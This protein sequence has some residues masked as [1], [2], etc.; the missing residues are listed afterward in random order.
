MSAD[1]ETHLDILG[2]QPLLGIYTQISLCYTVKDES[3]HPQIVEI[4]KAGLERLATSFPWLAGQVVR[5][6]S[7]SKIKPFE[8][9]PTLI[10][11][12]WRDDST[13]SSMDVL[14]Q[15]RFPF[16]LLDESIIAS[17]NTLPT[18]VEMSSP[19][20]VLALQ[21]N[22]IA[23]GLVLTVLVQ[24]QTMDMTGQGYVMHNLSKA[25][26]GEDF[27]KE[28]L[29]VGNLERPS[30]IPLL[31]ES[32][33]PGPELDRQII[34]DLPISTDTQIL[35]P[36]SVWLYFSF[37]PGS[38][39]T[40]KAKAMETLPS[41]FVSTDDVLSAFVWQ[42][43][44]RA[45]APRLKSTDTATFGRAVDV[46]QALGIPKTYLG[47]MQNMVYHTSNL[48]EL[49]E[50]PL[51]VLASQFRSAL[52]ADTLAYSTR[53]LTTFFNRSADKTIV[54]FAASIDP[55]KDFMLSSWAKIDCYH[56]DFGLGLGKPESVRRPQFTPVEG[57][58][59]L[60]PK[61]L[62]GEISLAICLREEDMERLKGDQEFLKYGHCI[63]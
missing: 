24:H 51:G 4:L 32:Y 9:L 21:A 47:L 2:Q 42:S 43:I 49:V 52:D 46:R 59:Y 1:W 14:R 17:R 28:E 29:S 45:R 7:V 37:P 50:I 48:Q 53:S 63:E 10:V 38:L 25:C 20:P 13:M 57:L 26:R 5:E 22:F 58:G 8:R 54:S 61:K 39:A 56:F 31:D 30:L 40:L 19:S 16:R 44:A 27:T 33:K 3:S 12:D 34:K 35:P 60:M 18:P 15:A 41:G 11:K 55:S 6:G 23:G 62:D 36:K